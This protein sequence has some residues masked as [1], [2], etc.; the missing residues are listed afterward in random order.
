ME[1]SDEFAMPTWDWHTWHDRYDQPGSN[2]ARR[3]SA[4]RERI[5][6]A[7]DASPRGPLQIISMCAGQGRDLLAV[8]P[9]HPRRDDVHARLVELDGRNAKIA[10]QS[11]SDTGLDGIEVIVG[12][13]GELASYADVAPADLVLVCG[14]FGNISV[15]DIQSTVAACSQLCKSGGTVIWTR[16]RRQPDLVPQI[17]RWFKENDFE[18][19]WLSSEGELFGIGAN[20]FTG[21]PRPLA[22]SKQMFSFTDMSERRDRI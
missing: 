18:Q 3:L 9:Q 17:C 14:V 7:L 16:H 21:K 11:A 19:L 13:A 10:R 15:E 2:M 12:D 6:I 1:E 5:R 22:G 8:L 4:V 20:R